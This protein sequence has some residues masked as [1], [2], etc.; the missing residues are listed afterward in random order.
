M[1]PP[2]YN[3]GVCRWCGAETRRGFKRG[4]PNELICECM[5]GRTPLEIRKDAVLD[6]YGNDPS[7]Y[8]PEVLAELAK[9]GLFDITAA[10]C[11]AGKLTLAEAKAREA[12]SYNRAV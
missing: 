4:R 1:T 7:A 5:D 6:K 12:A 2:S 10:F 9:D 3:R 11:P 8:T